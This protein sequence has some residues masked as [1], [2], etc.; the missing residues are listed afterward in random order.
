MSSLFSIIIKI[1]EDD[2]YI[3]WYLFGGDDNDLQLTQEI[4]THICEYAKNN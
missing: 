1:L 3:V 2:R 4:G